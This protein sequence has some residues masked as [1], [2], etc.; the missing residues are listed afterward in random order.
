MIKNIPFCKK[1]KL[2]E[3]LKW[4]WKNLE[5]EVSSKGQLGEDNLQEWN[6]EGEEENHYIDIK[7]LVKGT[8]TLEEIYERCNVTTLK[9]TK[10]AETTTKK[11]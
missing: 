8:W 2:D 9:S 1:V 3:T 11:G 10:Y 6:I 7:F 5:V 4:N